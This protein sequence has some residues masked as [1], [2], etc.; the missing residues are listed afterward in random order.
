[1]LFFFVAIGDLLELFLDFID[2][3]NVDEGYVL[4]AVDPLQLETLVDCSDIHNVH[5]FLYHWELHSFL[6]FTL[7][8]YYL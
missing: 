3:G 2:L 6:Y 1:V 5:L 4:L 7:P 8:H